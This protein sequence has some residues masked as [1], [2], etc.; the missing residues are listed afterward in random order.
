[1]VL[2][3]ATDLST[4]DAVRTPA[5]GDPFPTGPFYVQGPIFPEGTLDAD[6]DPG[7]ATSIGTFRC[8]GWIFDGSTALG[9]VS[10]AYEIDG[11][12]RIQVQGL[13]DGTR[14][15]TG[16]TGQFRN[17]RGEG[18]FEGINPENFSFRASFALQGAPK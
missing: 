10:Q 9:A 5:G 1:L 11:R 3:V 8:W 7:G 15:V 4:F 2:E 17:V 18:S 12:G 16:G 6:G 14:A 13:E